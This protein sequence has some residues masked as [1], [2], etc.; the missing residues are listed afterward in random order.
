MANQKMQFLKFT[1]FIFSITFLVYVMSH[2]YSNIKSSII[3]QRKQIFVETALLSFVYAFSLFWVAFGWKRILEVLSHIEIPSYFIW[4][5]LKSNVYKYLPGNVFNYVSRQIIARKVGVSHK[6]L[7]QSNLIETLL[8]GI[9]SLLLSGIILMMFY[10]F[11]VNKYFQFLNIYYV[12]FELLVAFVVLLYLSKYKNINI[13]RYWSIMA[14]Y[15][16]FFLG[17]GVIAWYILN[18]QMGLKFSFLLITAIY[19]FAWLVGFVT[20]GAPGGLG[21]RESVFVVLSNGV[22]GEADA[23]VLSLMLRFVSILG[24]ILLYFIA[25][26]MLRNFEELKK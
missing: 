10:G 2:S 22:L 15:F 6:I 14:F 9:V 11:L 26:Y 23:V 4:I 7:M 12:G 1:I 3:F 20:P 17:I 19:S 24:E 13:T 5:W 18:F 8:L 16:L 25:Q 21:V